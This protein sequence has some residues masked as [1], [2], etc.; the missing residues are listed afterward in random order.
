MPVQTNSELTAEDYFYLL[1]DHWVLHSKDPDSIFTRLHGYYV[2]R[3]V[4]IIK[5]SNSKT[6]LEVGCGDGWASGKLAEAGFDVV[7]VDWSANAIGYASILV[8]KAR[9]YA[10]DVR[11][12]S[13]IRKFPDKF[14]AV[15]LIEVIEHIPP[16]DC[17]ESLRAI[18]VSLK[19]G[20]VFVLTTPSTNLP[21][22]ST[23]HYRHFSEDV[24]R[25]LV[26]EAGDLDVIDIEGYG[27]MSAEGVFWR[28]SRW[29]DNR[30]FQI[31]QLKKILLH[32]FHRRTK[33]GPTPF[34]RCQGFIVTMR[35]RPAAAAPTST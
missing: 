10:M 18:T 32:D 12:E 25:S 22:T 34:D 2:R 20:G 13:F 1:P 27:D 11:D 4:E 35:R 16:K 24:L 19:P 31:K 5:S 9:F 15:A 14:D 6:V 30:Y 17:V 7:G 29:L 26:A 3:V 21:N 8:P 33:L 23:L 28:R